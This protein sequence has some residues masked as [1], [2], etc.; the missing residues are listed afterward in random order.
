VTSLDKLTLTTVTIPYT[1]QGKL[2]CDTESCEEQL[3]LVVPRQCR[4]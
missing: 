2:H 1:P 4:G 3:A